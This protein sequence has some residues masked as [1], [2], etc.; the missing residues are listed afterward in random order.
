MQRRQ[1]SM[2]RRRENPASSDHPIERTRPS[3]RPG[4]AL[5]P[6]LY[7]VATPIGNLGDVTLRALEVL[8]DVNLI[9]CEDTRVTA[10]LLNAHGITTKL[11][12]YHDHNA[13]RVRPALIERLQRG[14][15]LALVS[16]AGTPL[17]SDPGYRLVRE[18][19]ALGIP[20]IPLPGAS[21]IMAALVAAGL[22]TDR[23]LFA[24]FLPNKSAA[25]RSVLEEFATVR[26]TLLFLE[27]PHRL[28]ASLADMKDALGLR[29]AA[30]ARE[31]TK[32][33]EEIRRGTLSELA[34]HYASAPEPKGEIVIVVGPPFEQAPTEDSLDDALAPALKKMTLRDAVAKVAKDTGIARNKVY[35][36]ALELARHG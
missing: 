31:L 29:D 33:H 20:V 3:K 19:A 24:G 17:V 12:A 30:I 8:R 34:S 11:F 1:K 9:A 23:F 28:A 13:E 7:V 36:R 16:D 26:A 2:A 32:L 18:C 14:E 22:P 21:S 15:K 27:S 10:K 4:R 35:A 25:R 5:D 6:G